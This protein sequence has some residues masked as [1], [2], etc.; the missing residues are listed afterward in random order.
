MTRFMIRIGQ[1][2][3]FSCTP[4][5]TVL[6]AMERAG[7]AVIAVGCRGGG[8]GACKVRVLSGRYECGPMSRRHVTADDQAAGFALSC[9]LYPRTDLILER[10]HR[11][12][13]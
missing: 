11:T 1:E 6:R 7:R 4:D 10:V 9:K 3:G 5:Q 13:P 2:D 12:D 8:C